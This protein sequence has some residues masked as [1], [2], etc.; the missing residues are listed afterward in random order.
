MYRWAENMFEFDIF[1]AHLSMYRFKR[2]CD[3]KK[4]TV[5]AKISYWEFN[6]TSKLAGTLLESFP[7]I[8]ARPTA[9]EMYFP[10]DFRQITVFPGLS[11]GKNKF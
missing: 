6:W 3:K 9:Y 2:S 10:F 7:I 8:N 5:N 4:S 11:R 1:L